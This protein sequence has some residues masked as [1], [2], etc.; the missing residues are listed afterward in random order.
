MNAAEKKRNTELSEF[1][2]AYM[3]YKLGAAFRELKGML[4]FS[5]IFNLLLL[6]VDGNMLQGSGAFKGVIVA[7]V[8]FSTA[9]FGAYILLIKLK[10]FEILAA[11]VSGCELL[12]QGV[13]IY[14]FLCY[15]PPQLL[16]QAMGFLIIIILIFLVPNKWGYMLAVALIGS[17]GFLISAY[18]FVGGLNLVEYLAALVYI[19][20]AV[21]LCASA[22]YLREAS[23]FREYVA[24][25]ELERISA[26]DYLTNTANRYK[27]KEE[28]TKWMSYCRRNELPLALAFLDIDDFKQINDRCGH[29]AGD[30]VLSELTALISASLRNSDVISRWGGDEF[31]LLFPNTTLAGAQI[32]IERIRASVGRQ[33][34]AGGKRITCSFGVVEMKPDS[35]FE[36]LIKEADD[37]MYRGKK[38]GKKGSNGDRE[39]QFHGER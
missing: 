4:L 14:V 9:I 3:D 11:V 25:K 6:I 37:L 26:T 29:P 12:A 27:M 22:A 20:V 5:G 36:K 13:F 1:K 2:V 18:L 38:R 28:A 32:I 17:A 10:R 19:L 24:K 31:V 33:T 23:Q 30:A 15:N 8:A 7:R 21:S 34:F 16:I 39:P 35:D